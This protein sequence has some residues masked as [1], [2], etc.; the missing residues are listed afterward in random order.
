M[1]DIFIAVGCPTHPCPVPGDA[2]G[3]LPAVG[4]C[5][6]NGLEV[7]GEPIHPGPFCT[8]APVPVPNGFGFGLG[9]TC[10]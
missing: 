4:F 5:V 3:L 8:G 1:T 7:E 10:C 9:T 2:N 6:P